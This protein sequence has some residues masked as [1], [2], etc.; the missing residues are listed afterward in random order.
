MG[1]LLRENRK[2]LLG[3]GCA[4]LLA[5]SAILSYLIFSNELLNIPLCPSMIFSGIPCPTCGITRSM[6]NIFHGNFSRAYEY[7]PLGFLAVLVFIKRF[8]F[9][10]FQG[11]FVNKILDGSFFNTAIAVTFFLLYFYNL[12]KIIINI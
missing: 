2:I 4:E 1:I 10:L 6:W 8:L 7:N 9:L 12:L 3:P 5:I 11:T